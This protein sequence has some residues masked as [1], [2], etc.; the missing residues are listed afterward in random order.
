M[1]K[2]KLCALLNVEDPIEL[3][4]ALALDT[5]LRLLQKTSDA[6]SY[7]I[8]RLVAEVRREEIPLQQHQDWVDTICQ[9]IGDWFE[10][11]REEFSDLFRFDSEIDHLQ[12]WQV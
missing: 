8:H 4:N 6:D 1:K 12:V 5:A 10:E 2:R 3:T 7:S 9:R 11:R